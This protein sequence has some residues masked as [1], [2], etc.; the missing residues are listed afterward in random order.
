MARRCR[1]SG[2]RRRRRQLRPRCRPR[3]RSCRSRKKKKQRREADRLPHRHGVG[4]LPAQ[5]R[6]QPGTRRGSARA[7]AHSPL[8]P[9]GRAALARLEQRNKLFVRRRLELLLDPGSPFL[10]LSALAAMHAYDGDAPQALMVTGV[11]VVSGREVMITAGRQLAEGRLLVS[12]LDQ[13]D[14]PCPGDRAS[15]PPSGDQ[16]RGLRRRVPAAR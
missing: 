5:P 4:Q 2:P 3:R 10:E 8:R 16:S 15:E 7:A 6:A 11:G 13:E 9:T 1:R 14:R 12:A